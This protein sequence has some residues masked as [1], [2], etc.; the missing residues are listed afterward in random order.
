MAFD[1]NKLGELRPNQIIT[2]FG[3]GSIVDAVKDSVTI[4]DINYWSE[5]GKK[6]IDGRLA[7]YLGVNC[8]Y[9]PRTSH[10]GDI[11]VT[12]FPYMHVCSNLKCGRLFDMREMFDLDSYLRFGVTCPDCHRT[13]YPSRFITICEN[14]HMGDFP[15]QWWVHQGDTSCKGKLKMYSTGNTS[16]LAD[17]WV[18]CMTCGAKRSMSGATQRDNFDGMKCSGHHPFRPN[19]KN[20]KCYKPLLPS[21]R[22]ASNVYFSVSRSAISIPPW[23]NPLYNL[24]DEHL[25]LIENYK[26]D[27]GE[28]GI[29]K[30]YEKYFSV[31]TREEFD[32]ALERRLNNITEFTEIKKMEYD[33]ITHHNDPAY[34]S[35]K[36]H[37][38]A[39]EDELPA[40]FKKYFERIIRVTRL[41]EVRVLLGFTRVDAPDPDADVQANIVYLSKGKE[42]KWLPAAEINGEGIFIEFNKSTINAWL[43]NA[44]VKALSQKYEECY[45]QFCEEKQWTI[46]VPRNAVYVLMH[47][48]A[49]LLIKQMAMSSGYSSSAIRERIY[50]GESMNG[51]LL[52]TGSA[53]KEGSLGGLVELGNTNKLISL[54][55]DAFQEALLCTND[56]E[57]LNTTPAGNNS[58]GAAC[59]SCCMIS[60]TACE[61]GNRMLDRGLVVPIANRDSQAYFKELVG[62]LCQLEI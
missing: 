57:C 46:T 60:E 10:N 39:E 40:G 18:E 27:F 43:S 41:R 11:P 59:H 56:P 51:I 22:G 30:V 6:I 44:R 55:R 4:L 36:K 35:N 37:F 5:K 42:E 32:A 15:W 2:T 24:I 28:A 47:T 23:I 48:F 1:N 62:E 38:K 33:A 34:S 14:G 53:D 16:T 7:S 25:R 8:F 29:I 17:M 58:N 61:N 12:T 26:E 19:A 54:M 49:H 20:E 52:Y 21:Q 3:P 9:M 45:K 50:F 13:A 31:F